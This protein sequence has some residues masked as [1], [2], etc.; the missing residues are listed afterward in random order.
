MKSSRVSRPPRPTP[1]A[2]LSGQ[3]APV[4]RRLPAAF[5]EA[6]ALAALERLRRFSDELAASQYTRFWE[7]IAEAAT[8]A[9]GDGFPGC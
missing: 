9:T 5:G 8:Q 3:A 4:R 1:G 6:A 2:V 7:V